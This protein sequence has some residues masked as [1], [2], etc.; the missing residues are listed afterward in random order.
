LRWS[1][2]AR[3]FLL[4]GPFLFQAIVFSLPLFSFYYLFF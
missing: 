1:A 3:A 2:T 4:H